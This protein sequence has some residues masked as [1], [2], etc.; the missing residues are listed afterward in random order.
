MGKITV[1]A[2]IFLLNAD[3]KLLICHPTNHPLDLWSIPK[4]KVEEGEDFISA[5]IRETYE[6]TN[7]DVST[8]NRIIPLPLITYVKKKKVIHP[9]LIWEYDNKT[10]PW[11]SFD[12]KCNSNVPEDKGGFPEMDDFKWVSIDEARELLHH[13][14]RESLNYIQDFI[15]L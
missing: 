10:L 5:A 4:G 14:Q 7:I 6:E 9:F 11:N 15:N 3:N 12:I 2:G 13:S 8:Y 1:A